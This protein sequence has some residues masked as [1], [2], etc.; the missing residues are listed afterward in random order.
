[1][2]KPGTDVDRIANHYDILPTFAA[3]AGTSPKEQGQLHGLSLVPLLKDAKAPWE[4]RFRV[5]HKGRWGKGQAE[6]SR[7]NGFAVRN[8]RFR[9]VGRSA[10]YDMEKDPSQKTNVMADHPEI[11]KKMNAAYDQWYDGAL[12]NMVNEDA[13]L[14]GHNTFHLMFWKQYGMDSKR[15]QLPDTEK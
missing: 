2:L 12:P 5:F 10:L 9:L 15:K 8:Q 6:S 3:I 11:A 1:V 4:D 13:P 7:D 14:T